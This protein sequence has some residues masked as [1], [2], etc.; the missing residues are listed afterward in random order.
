MNSKLATQLEIKYLKS[1]IGGT[2]LT[3][4]EMTLLVKN[5]EEDWAA[6]SK[7]IDATPPFSE[8]FKVT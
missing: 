4:E 6:I 7:M 5:R 3:E 8:V 2:K 1:Q